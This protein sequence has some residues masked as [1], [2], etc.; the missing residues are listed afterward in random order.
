[1]HRGGL[2]I[3]DCD[4]A[5]LCGGY[6]EIE[7]GR[8][9]HRLQLLAAIAAAQQVGGV[10]LIAKLDRLSRNAGF[11]FTLRDVGGSLSAATCPTRTC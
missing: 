5:A 8:E 11:I 2:G 7:S 3:T 10:P 4:P 1:M 6:V 9:N